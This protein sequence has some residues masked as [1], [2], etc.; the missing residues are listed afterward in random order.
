VNEIFSYDTKRRIKSIKNVKVDQ[1]K[2]TVLYWMERDQRVS[3][4]W[5]LI[6][7]Y[8]FA[9]KYNMS[10]KVVFFL[11]KNLLG[12]ELRRFHFL[13]NGLV[14]TNEKLRLL[15]IEFILKIAEP[16]NELPKLIEEYSVAA[17]F[18]D[19]N[20][21]KNKQQIINKINESIDIPFAEV[22]AHNIIPIWQT[23][24]KQEFGARTIRLKINRLLDD[25]LTE[26]PKIEPQASTNNQFC[27]INV[28]DLLHKLNLDLSVQPISWI[29]PGETAAFNILKSFVEHKL[30]NYSL[31]RNDPTKEYISNLSIHLHFGHISAQRIALILRKFNNDENASAFLEEMIVR[32]ELSD[33]F[34][35]YNKNYDN[36]NG[37]PNWAKI[38]LNIHRIDKRDY[39]YS[40]S[41][42]EKAETHDELWNAA[43]NEL[44]SNGK[45]HGYMRMYWAKKILEW[46]KSPEDAQN[47]AIYLNDKYALDGIDPN[48]FTGIAWSIGGIHDRAWFE[49]PIFGKVRYM[50]FNG[51]KRKFDVQKYIIKF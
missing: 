45:M 49:K 41:Q 23:S 48:G 8:E 24:N 7:A 19:Q 42:F 30:S 32:R 43:Q 3:D 38:S 4:N 1:A 26:F 2:K 46:T 44:L 51:A 5:A 39:I 33:N 22:D 35:Y 17:L 13:I 31:L 21:L 9:A 25:Y 16:E 34:V 20:P 6:A 12:N 11:T 37:F 47:I 50:N 36:F 14:E 29:K 40:I 10:L 28:E 18:T 15:N 27:E